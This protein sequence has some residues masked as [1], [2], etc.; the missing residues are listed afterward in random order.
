MLDKLITN[1]KNSLPGAKK[2]AEDEEQLEETEETQDS[3][4][5]SDTE[6][7]ESTAEDEKKKRT[8]MLIRVV[9]ILLLGYLAL[10]HFFLNSE[11]E[12]NID[13]IAAN[14]PRKRKKPKQEVQQPTEE[15]KTEQTTAPDM[16]PA[17]VT[18]VAPTVPNDTPPPV[19][20][21]NI[22]DKPAEETAPAI[23]ETPVEEP[24]AIPPTTETIET[25]ET[26]QTTSTTPTTGENTLDNRLDQLIDNVEEKEK[27][28]EKKPSL[29]DKIVEEE[30]QTPPPPYD[31]LGRGLVYNCKDK[32]WACIDKPNYVV[33]NKNMKWNKSKG[34]SQEC[35]IQN[36][37]GSDEDCIKVQKFYVSSNQ[38]TDFCGK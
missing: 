29:A 2:N 36:V 37:Y 16:N 26:T 7:S 10:D 9:V 15:V 12:A 20:N 31:V 21:I 35:V 38:P 3:E 24:I 8:S 4:A 6:G 25:T 13:Q 18:T 33:C 1:I 27:A 22:A 5:D 14:V 17:E 11:Q 28:P 30:V 32:F 23:A 19:E 34:N